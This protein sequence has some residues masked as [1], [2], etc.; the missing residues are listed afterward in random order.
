MWPA[1]GSAVSGTGLSGTVSLLCC[2]GR[3]RAAK[4]AFMARSGGGISRLLPHSQG[5]WTRCHGCPISNESNIACTDDDGDDP[6]EADSEGEARPQTPGTAWCG[7]RCPTQGRS[8]CCHTVRRRREEGKSPISR[9]VSR[10]Q[11]VMQTGQT[12]RPFAKATTYPNGDNRGKA[13]EGV[14]RKKIWCPLLL[15]LVLLVVLVFFG[16]L[17]RLP[18]PLA[19]LPLAFGGADQ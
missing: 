14:G 11:K 9:P 1:D 16:V 2:L 4:T 3:P 10:R 6:H 5:E 12:P 8:L 19:P 18:A 7:G 15:Y 17:L 13:L